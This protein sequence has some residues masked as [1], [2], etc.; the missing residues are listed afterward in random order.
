MGNAKFSSLVSLEPKQQKIQVKRPRRPTFASCAAQLRFD[1]VQSF[2]Q[3]VRR[4]VKV[5]Q[6]SRV[7]KLVLFPRPANG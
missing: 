1:L 3:R 6:R 4:T 7:E 5:N 2:Q